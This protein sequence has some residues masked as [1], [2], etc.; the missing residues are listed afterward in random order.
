MALPRSDMIQCRIHTDFLLVV[1]HSKSSHTIYFVLRDASKYYLVR[2]A[3]ETKLVEV[4]SYL[5]KIGLA[6][7]PPPSASSKPLFNN[8]DN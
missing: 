7:R 4:S 2:F 1:T 8:T 6:R 3:A 5:V